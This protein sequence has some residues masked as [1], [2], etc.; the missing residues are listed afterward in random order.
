MTF[1]AERL[2]AA[3]HPGGVLRRAGPTPS[4]GRATAATETECFGKRLS[5]LKIANIDAAA[6]QGS[7]YN[8][9]LEERVKAE[10][11]RR[12]REHGPD[13]SKWCAASLP[14]CTPHPLLLPRTVLGCARNLRRQ[15]DVTGPGNRQGR[16]VEWDGS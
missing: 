8:P 12:E 16:G 5:F 3:H 15:G 6:L 11:A 13:M 4:D 1:C 9:V 7:M 2:A 14:P 10:H